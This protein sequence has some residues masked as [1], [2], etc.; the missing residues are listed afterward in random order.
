M[1]AEDFENLR[2]KAK[3]VEAENR[4]FFKKLGKKKPQNLDIIVHELDKRFF[5]KF[6]CLDCGNCCRTLG[7]RII[8]IDIKRLSQHLKLKE[9][10]FISTYLK[11]DEDNDYVFQSMPCPFLCSDNYCSV[12]KYR[13]KA[14]KEFPHTT[15]RRFY[16]VL[17][18]TLQNTFI[19]P[20]VFDIVEELKVK[21]K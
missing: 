3:K 14:C 9:N 10:D 6:D 13:P 12:Y 15:Q 16:Q 2:I 19:C 20:V 8:D 17:N 4:A 18:L 11:I 1:E 5:D 21:F 7:P